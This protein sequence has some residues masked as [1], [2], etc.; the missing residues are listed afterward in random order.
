MDTQI[1]LP[2]LWLLILSG[3]LIPWLNA[4]ATKSVDK[5]APERL[6]VWERRLRKMFAG[7]ASLLA[8]AIDVIVNGGPVTIGSL[9][10]AVALVYMSQRGAWAATKEFAVNPNNVLAPKRG[11]DPETVAHKA[12]VFFDRLAAA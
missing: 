12:A 8:V 11:L 6:Q 9:V 1:I 3:V 5:S 2:D 4:A 10:P 7:M